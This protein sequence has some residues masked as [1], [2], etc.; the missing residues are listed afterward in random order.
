MQ[1]GLWR[2]A[3][4]VSSPIHLFLLFWNTGHETP[5]H[6]EVDDIAAFRGFSLSS[7]ITKDRIVS[8]WSFLEK[9]RIYLT[10][11]AA[12][13]YTAA[14]EFSNRNSTDCFVQQ[15]QIKRWVDGFRILS[16]SC[17]EIFLWDVIAAFCSRQ[18]PIGNR[19]ACTNWHSLVGVL[20][21][22]LGNKLSLV[23]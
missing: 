19:N 16:V 5:V 14:A 7:R 6:H 15:N 23:E 20:S 13:P 21:S 8:T 3:A 9:W 22:R 18:R 11:C 1:F 17:H 2:A 4:F 12:H 10:N